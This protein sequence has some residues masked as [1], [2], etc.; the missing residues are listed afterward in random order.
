MWLLSA[1]GRHSASDERKAA[2]GAGLRIDLNHSVSEGDERFAVTRLVRDAG[3]SIARDA[4]ADWGDYR[5]TL[6]DA[7]TGAVL[8]AV[9]FDSNLAPQARAAS[10]ALSVRCPLPP[11]AFMVTVAK[12]RPGGFFQ[13][14]LTGRGDA[15]IVG[16]AAAT[17]ARV[18]AIVE[19]GEP[20]ERVDLAIVAEGYGAAEHPKFIEDAK[21]TAAYL[22][23]V[24]PFRSRSRDFN[25]HAVFVASD[26]SGATDAYLGQRRRTAFGAAY[27]SGMNERTVSLGDETKLR[28]AASTVPYDF[29]LVAVNSGRY[30]GSAYFGGPAV[31]S[32]DSAA[33]RYLVLHELAHSIAGLAE[34]YYIPTPDGPAYR[35]NVEPWHPNV[36]T[37]LRTTKW[38]APH[39]GGP[40]YRG[41]VEPWHP[42]VTTAVE[43]TKWRPAAAAP[44]TWNKAQY[45][46]YF[47]NYVRRYSA[48][49]AGGASEAAVEKLMRDTAARQAVLLGRS[50]RVGLYEG[51]DGYAKGVYRS[52]ADCIMFSLQTQYYCTACTAALERAIDSRLPK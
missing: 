46:R 18:E 39:D 9:A 26:E 36:T 25:V 22:F 15:S 23:A 4:L 20:R 6:T 37:S 30:G 35:G 52:E 24:E 14:L 45:E 8:S 11:A 19:H 12:R 47:A 2:S 27:G 28:D 38:E 33:A 31:V 48:L 29:L 43:T 40:S 21:R 5:L 13:T 34:E 41:N 17:N 10:T 50:R 1:C 42:N 49:R 44:S 51:A 7:G 16:D 32:I 3:S